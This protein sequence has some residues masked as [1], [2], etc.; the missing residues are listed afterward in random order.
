MIGDS[1]LDM[2]DYQ[3]PVLFSK[4]VTDSFK[5]SRFVLSAEIYETAW[6][7]RNQNGEVFKVSNKD[8]ADAF[9]QIIQNW[10]AWEGAELNN[11]G[12]NPDVTLGTFVVK[13]FSEGG[14]KSTA[15]VQRR[16]FLHLINAIAYSSRH[17]GDFDK[18]AGE[19][20]LEKADYE[21]ALSL[22]NEYSQNAQAL[23]G[24]SN[25]KP[26]AA[27]S[28]SA[29]SFQGGGNILFYGA[30][31]T[32]KSH[33]VWE[34][35]GKENLSFATVFH[36]DMQNSDFTGTLKPG[37]DGNGNVTYAFR[38]G[39]FARAVA[40]A[41]ANPDRK[42]FLVIEE[43]N[44]AVA[45]AIFGELFQLLDRNPDGSGR[46]HV[47]FPSPEFGQWFASETG[48]E[49][50]TLSLPANLWILATMNSADQGV[51]PLDT[52]FRRRW[53]QR[54]LPIDYAKAPVVP[55]SYVTSTGPA[56]TDWKTFVKA[57]NDFLVSHL[58]IGE[59]RLL[60]PRFV[61][62]QE[63]DG[64]TLPGKLLIYLWDDL[65]RHHGRTE[66]FASGIHTYGELDRRINRNEQI[67]STAFLASLG[68]NN[69]AVTP[70]PAIEE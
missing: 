28:T 67:F 46:Y 17:E 12:V 60:G 50:E 56:S 57:L 33:D 16:G 55:V 45:A 58:E 30:P 62:E 19:K 36:P 40:C 47:D 61:E 51:Y 70:A 24:S 31:G 34:M 35:V 37:V 32:G 42:V 6:G 48:K 52:A 59:D 22:L 23:A 11:N 63:L 39:P 26:A 15:K 65:L 18:A 10:D 53:R 54:Y 14:A 5:D 29:T 69:E 25:E 66:L 43:L 44:R 41:W 13:Y 8:M 27:H 9:R 68:A 49:M 1:K 4:K 20:K 7:F 64:G 21:A 3:K 2:T 38:P